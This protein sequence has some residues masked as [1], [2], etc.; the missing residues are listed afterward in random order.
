MAPARVPGFER[1]FRVPGAAKD[2]G[3]LLLLGELGCLHCHTPPSA[4]ALPS[5]AAPVLTAAGERLRPE[6]LRRFLNDPAA[7]KPGTTMPQVLAELPPRERAQV[8]EDLVHFL[9][10]TGT[11][12]SGR[13]SPQLIAQGRTI[14]HQIGC[15]LCH[16]SRTATAA[17]ERQT[18]AS[19]PLERLADKYTLGGLHRF[20]QDPLSVRPSGRMPGL[21]SAKQAEAVAA[22]LLQGAALDSPNLHYWYYEGEWERL[23]DFRQL[24]PRRQGLAAGFDLGVAQRANQFALRFLGYFP[25]TQEGEYHFY[26]TSDDGARVCIAGQVVVE[27]DGIHPPQ[28]ASGSIRL[29]AGVHA[30]EVTYFNGPGGAELV[31]EVAGPGRPRQ[32]LGPLLWL[33]PD[34]GPAA[35]FSPQA[36]SVARGQQAFERWGCAACHEL[37]QH[38]RRLVP[39]K[40]APPLASLRPGRGCL[41]P[42][43]PPEVPHYSLDDCQ[44]QAL[45][46]AL[47]SIRTV[48]VTPPAPAEI[49][50]RYLLAFNCYACHERDHQGGIEESL[51]AFVRGAQPEMGEEGRLPPSLTGVGSKLTPAWLAHVLA[52]GAH[53]RPY[54]FTHMPRFGAGNTQSLA[55]AL[56]VV[57]PL[58]TVPPVSLGLPASKVKDLGRFLVGAQALGC[59]KCHTFAGHKAEGVQGLD[60]T[61]MARRLRRDWFHR[62]LIDPQKYRPG[63]R[64]PSAWP[65]GESVL[66]QV[67]GGQTAQQIE[68]IWVYL[69]DG[70]RAR[71]PV[72]VQRHPILLV[73]KR[74][75]ILYRNFLE[76]A[77]A[78]AIAVG[79]PEQAHLAF[80]ANDLRL[81]LLWHGAFVDASRHWTDR[82]IGFEPP[83]GE[84]V[85]SLPAGLALAVLPRDTAPWPTHSA[86]QLPGYQFQGY[87]LDGQRRPTFLYTCAGVEVED[88]PEALSGPRL[89]QVRRQLVLH[90][91]QPVMGLYFR[92]AAAQHLEALGQGWYRV[93]NDWYLHLEGPAPA[94]LRR[95]QE[96]YELLMPIVFRD[97]QARLREEFCWEWPQNQ[98]A[99]KGN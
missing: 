28:S 63:T 76:G 1:F 58:V 83:A 72:G 94:R 41:S 43:P 51:N 6:Y 56:S 80:D 25:V 47:M 60:M 71:L 45:E 38:G 92:A 2:K 29:R 90:A 49:V 53:E 34:K 24:R 61:L 81:A 46:A 68:A 7:T 42:S 54:L 93:E 70:E 96:R 31:V 69:S 19:V 22:Y 74:E 11:P 86:R 78:R 18:P 30:V 44:R 14:Y 75:A 23:P 20:L 4:L 67:L 26:V 15:V 8:V 33:T 17:A 37:Q 9:A 99:P 84:G 66:P 55:Q 21:L 59:I 3:G 36:E 73:P 91:R 12:R 79:Y 88:F 40:P 5:K 64:M 62:Y 95:S 35:G 89:P 57:D 27:N 97:G 52:E 65:G 85:L 39:L 16:G 13:S 50:R 48:P 82:G 32:A 10:A 87:R 77:G 98:P